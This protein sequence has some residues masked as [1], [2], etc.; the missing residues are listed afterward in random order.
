MSNVS[1]AAL[2]SLYWVQ[3]ISGT[4]G[5]PYV[6]DQAASSEGLAT[7]TTRQQVQLPLANVPTTITVPGKEADMSDR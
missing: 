3:R 7:G 2:K 5:G 1:E 4:S 6:I